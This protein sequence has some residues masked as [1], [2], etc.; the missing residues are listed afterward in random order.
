MLLLLSLRPVFVGS[1][2]ER[3]KRFVDDSEGQKVI[4]TDRI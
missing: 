3:V 2:F 1:V 4:H